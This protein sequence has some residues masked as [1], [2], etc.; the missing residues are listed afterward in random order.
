MAGKLIDSS[1]HEQEEGHC[2]L[3]KFTVWSDAWQTQDK[4]HFI[5]RL[6]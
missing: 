5:E 4:A 1:S 3:E 2:C 6:Y